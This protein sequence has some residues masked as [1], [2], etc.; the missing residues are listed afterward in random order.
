[1]TISDNSETQSMQTPSD[2]KDDLKRKLIEMQAK[3]STLENELD[4]LRKKKA[5]TSLETWIYVDS[6]GDSTDSPAAIFW[7]TGPHGAGRACMRVTLPRRSARTRLPDPPAD[8]GVGWQS[9]AARRPDR[10]CGRS[11]Q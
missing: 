9:R 4:S 5:K 2:N 6:A 10:H 11:G 3:V 1:M 7:G 8:R